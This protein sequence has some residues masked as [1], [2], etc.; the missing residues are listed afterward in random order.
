MK[1]IDSEIL[2]EEYT[3]QFASKIQSLVSKRQKLNIPQIEIARLISKSERTIQNF[4]NGRC[5]D[6]YI[7]YAYNQ[8]IKNK[9]GI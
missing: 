5:L 7:I 3:R 2:R 9:L 1:I 4:E 8:I 6:C